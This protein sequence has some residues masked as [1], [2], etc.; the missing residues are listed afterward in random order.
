MAP[1]SKHQGRTWTLPPSCPT[2]RSSC[3][4]SRATA[5]SALPGGEIAKAAA[6]CVGDKSD[7]WVTKLII[8]PRST[9]EFTCR[10]PDL[11]V[12]ITVGPF[13]G[14]LT[15]PDRCFG[16]PPGPGLPGFPLF[17]DHMITLYLQ[18]GT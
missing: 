16:A 17:P 18:E 1:A 9:F 15:L 12:A 3:A 4:R 5:R 11:G 7:V 6:S 10:S 13:K 14:T 2:A 8:S